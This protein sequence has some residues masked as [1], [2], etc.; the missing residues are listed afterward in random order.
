MCRR[1]FG[2]DRVSVG[3]RS[4]FGLPQEPRSALRTRDRRTIVAER[5]CEE[6]IARGAL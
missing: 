4:R 5:A 1:A 6:A 3:K 2:R